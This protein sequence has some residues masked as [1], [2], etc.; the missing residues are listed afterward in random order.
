MSVLVMECPYCAAERATFSARG[1]FKVGETKDFRVLMECPFCHNG[2]VANVTQAKGHDEPVRYNGP[3]T[4]ENFARLETFPK[5]IADDTPEYLPQEI[6]RHYLQACL[7]RRN[8]SHDI[9]PMAYRKVL[10]L[11]VKALSTDIEAWKLEK[12]IDKMAEEHLITPALRDWAHEIR[13]DG[14]EGAHEAEEP[15]ADSV[16]QIH[17]F[18]HAFLLYTFTLPAMIAERRT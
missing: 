11:A 5:A 4:H 2:I 8:K 7:C 14:N 15:T 1:Q 16:S 9:A 18:T 3:L 10:E 6:Q 17:F 12:R 13:L